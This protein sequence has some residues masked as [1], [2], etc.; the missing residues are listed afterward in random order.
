[1]Q[2]EV[3]WALVVSLVVTAVVLH[4]GLCEWNP[5]QRY[6]D[7]RRQNRQVLLFIYHRESVSRLLALLLGLATPAG[8]LGVAYCCVA[9]PSA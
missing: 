1:M 5:H 8:L 6:V 9:R 7:D 4:F 2:K 3:K